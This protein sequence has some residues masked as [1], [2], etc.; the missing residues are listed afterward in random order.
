VSASEGALWR[1]KPIASPDDD[2]L[3]RE[4]FVRSAVEVIERSWSCDE[5]TVVG[6]L[7]PWG[8]G[9]TSLINLID[10]EL[11]SRPDP[12]HIAYFTPWSA[13]DSAGV[14]AEFYAAIA[15]ALPDDKSKMFRE[16][17]G[18]LIGLAAPLATL[19]PYVGNA[20]QGAAQRASE[21]LYKPKPWSVAFQ[22]ASQ[23]LM[24]QGVRV[25]VVVDDVDRLQ[26]PELAEVL[27]V[28]RLLG[29]FP[30]V[31]YLLSYDERTVQEALATTSL[32]K[33]VRAASL[34]MEKIV[35]HPLRVPA[36]GTRARMSLLRQEIAQAVE[37]WE[38]NG[39]ELSLGRVGSC[40]PDM[41]RLASTL[42]TIRRFGAS[43]SLEFTRHQPGEVDAGDLVLLTFLAVC[44]PLLYRELPYF[45]EEL[46]S[47]KRGDYTY[48]SGSVAREEFDYKA[49]FE[50]VVNSPLSGSVG[51]ILTT[52]FPAVKSGLMDAVAPQIGHADYFDRYFV[53]GVGDGDVSDGEVSDAFRAAVRGESEALHHLIY[54]D[55]RWDDDWALLVLS[56][57]PDPES[58][59]KARPVDLVRALSAVIVSMPLEVHRFRSAHDWLRLY[60]EK[61]VFTCLSEW[62]E[63]DLVEATKLAPLRDRWYWV[64]RISQWIEGGEGASYSWVADLTRDLVEDSADRTLKHLALRDAAPVDESAPWELLIL[65]GC[66]DVLRTR[67]EEGIVGGEF[68]A[69]DLAARFV[70]VSYVLGA[71]GTRLE[72]VNREAWEQMAPDAVADW[73]ARWDEPPVPGP[74]ID[75]PNTWP[76][77]REFVRGRLRAPMRIG[78][79]ERSTD[80]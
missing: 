36:T 72:G 28:V 55:G 69:E 37:P 65:H 23:A 43:L 1:D 50:A 18:A 73:C 52:L 24:E 63:G 9:K 68:T 34:F 44:E 74:A 21:G 45:S 39:H 30:G 79:P 70:N 41:T 48:S 19:I 75:H 5:S 38:V 56:K 2:H 42:R 11:T 77:R 6:L 22:E 47:G 15:A 60:V 3:G 17:A 31:Q 53:G 10:R 35:Q 40:L 51:S 20:A 49:T 78:D 7:G 16:K 61:V 57:F 32:V 25:L 58:L 64:H 59:K 29:R 4:S 80:A 26:G 12:W 62:R 27:K 54:R 8:S 33:D 46:T 76:S 66:I 71:Q 67:F 13:G 14:M